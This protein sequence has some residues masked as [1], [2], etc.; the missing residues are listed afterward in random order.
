MHYFEFR[1]VYLKDLHVSCI[2]FDHRSLTLAYGLK[3]IRKIA[4]MLHIWI[5]RCHWGKFLVKFNN[6]V[7]VFPYLLPDEQSILFICQAYERI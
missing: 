7:D 6:Q 2:H 5:I 4:K 3:R 1:E